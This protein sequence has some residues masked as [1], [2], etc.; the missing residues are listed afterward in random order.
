MQSEGTQNGLRDDRRGRP[1]IEV[2]PE[3]AF[4]DAALHD[5][6]NQLMQR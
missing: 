5:V 2:G 3:D 1:D 4:G 6:A